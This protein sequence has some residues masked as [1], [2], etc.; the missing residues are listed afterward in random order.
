MCNKCII[1]LN[2]NNSCYY[3]HYYYSQKQNQKGKSNSIFWISLCGFW[4]MVPLPPMI[5][6]PYLSPEYKNKHVFLCLLGSR[7]LWQQ[8]TISTHLI[9]KR[10]M[11][12]SLHISWI[13]PSL[14]KY[15]LY[16]IACFLIL[17][18]FELDFPPWILKLLPLKKS[19]N[20]CD[21][22]NLPFSSFWDSYTHCIWRIS[23]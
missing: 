11:E 22:S 7:T 20:S 9:K 3:H 21:F 15:S 4:H 12:A 10:V 23:N 14:R 13:F 5:S 18:S 16:I 1:K 6:H 8:C 17:L 19:K 2:V